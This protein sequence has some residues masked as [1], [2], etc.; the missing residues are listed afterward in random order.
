ML[1][2]FRPDLFQE[3]R[4]QLDRLR[5]TIAERAQRVIGIQAHRTRERANERPSVKPSRNSGE[6][7]AVER[8]DNPQRQ[9]SRGYDLRKGDPALD[10]RVMKRVRHARLI[11]G[12]R[13]E[14]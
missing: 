7:P 1:A 11:D 14:R 6:A 4:R 2:C 5:Q 10:P 12:A 8:L 3:F 9:A 13:L